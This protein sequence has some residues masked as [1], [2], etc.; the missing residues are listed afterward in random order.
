MRLL[1]KILNTLVF[2]AANN[3]LKL[4]SY[5]NW[6]KSKKFKEQIILDKPYEGQKIMLLALYEKGILRN[7]VIGLLQSAKKQG[8]YTICVNT[9]KITN[10]EKHKDIIDCYID[11]HN[12]GRDFGS[13]K[14]GFEH[15][16]RRGMQKDCPRLLM[17]NDSIFFSS[18][19]IDKFLEEMLESKIEALGATENFEIEH[20]LGSFCIALDKKILNNEVFQ[21][22]W[23]N[24]ELTDVRPDVIKRGEMV[25]SKTLKRVVTSPD[26][27]K[28]LYDSTRIAKVLETH[29]DLIDS[30]VTL[31]RAS[32]LLPWPTYS[33]GIMV[34]GLTKKYLYS[35]HKL[36]RLWGKDVK[37]NEIEDFGMNFV[38]STRSLAGFVYKHLEDL[39]LTYDDVY[40]TICIEA[41]AH[42]V[43]TFSRGS[44][45][46]QNNIFLHHIG[47]PLIKLDGLYRGM[48]IARDVESLAQDLDGHQVDEFRQ[49]MYS[50]P[51]GGN[52]FFGWKRAAFYRGLI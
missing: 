15:L 49:L 46:H 25:L 18:K 4:Q 12:Y 42:F 51:F 37:S 30:L 14:T 17:I 40:K 32:E 39:D 21:N 5:Q 3:Y 48:F 50:R 31:S 52:V 33:S 1:S 11:K 38:M 41:I 36:M 10:I 22:Y 23:K 28:A 29:T 43:E 9:L 8:I 47:M 45:I 6:K 24:Y 44:Q 20:H 34:K 16:F 13:Y 27:F 35:N 2:Q 26:Q 7:D 19:H